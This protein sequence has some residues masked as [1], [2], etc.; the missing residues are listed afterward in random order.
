MLHPVIVQHLD[1]LRALCEQEQ[2]S[3]CVIFGS[4]TRT[5]FRAGI[6][7][8]DII[9]TFEPDQVVTA[10]R[11]SRLAQTISQ[12][13]GHSV[14]LHTWSEIHPKIQSIIKRNGVT[15]FERRAG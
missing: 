1:A 10:F 9:V 4:A 8:V 6:S 5:D 3:Q 13:V 14:D 15:I 11:L 7:D 12:I 2:I